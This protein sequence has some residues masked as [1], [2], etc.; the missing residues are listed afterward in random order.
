[1]VSKVLHSC[2]I[3]KE[4]S[5]NTD[6]SFGHTTWNLPPTH[7]PVLYKLRHELQLDRT[8]IPDDFLYVLQRKHWL[9]SK[10]G[11]I[12]VS[13]PLI[14]L[15][16]ATPALW[17]CQ[18]SPEGVCMGETDIYLFLHVKTRRLAWG[19]FDWDNRFSCPRPT[20]HLWACSIL[21]IT[22]IHCI[23]RGVSLF[24]MHPAVSTN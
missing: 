17:S 14:H 19:W 24:Q 16:T 10:H 7:C 20:I 21:C 11:L 12:Q 13:A 22:T 4:M 1:M 23:Y 18:T 2:W 5:L 8:K 9:I 6:L 3:K 15:Q